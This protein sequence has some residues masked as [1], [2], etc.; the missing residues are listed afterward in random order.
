MPGLLG[1]DFGH[2]QTFVLLMLI[3]T[4]QFRVLIVRERRCFWDS[5]PGTLLLASTGSTMAIFFLMGAFGFIIPALGARETGLALAYSLV[6]TA[7][8]DCPKR[9]FFKLF[10][11]D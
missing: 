7:V 1:L 11:V 3:F 9:L 2:M 8:L 4:S 5:M 6:F 10:H